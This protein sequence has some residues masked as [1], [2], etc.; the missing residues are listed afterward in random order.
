[1][2]GNIEDFHINSVFDYGLNFE[3]SS[4]VLK[5]LASS[6]IQ[7]MG[8][9]YLHTP[10]GNRNLQVVSDKVWVDWPSLEDAL[11]RRMNAYL[12]AGTA[13]DSRQWGLLAYQGGGVAIRIE[14]LVDDYWW[15][16]C[17]MPIMEDYEEWKAHL[18]AG[19]AAA[20]L[21]LPG[22]R[23]NLSDTRENPTWFTGED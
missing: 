8:A 13:L 9:P 21:H 5:E 15:L 11:T 7:L 10:P 19:P 20:L 23:S 6:R 17:L 22:S 4:A 12:D 1:M 18:G 16:E 3:V 2:S 14:H